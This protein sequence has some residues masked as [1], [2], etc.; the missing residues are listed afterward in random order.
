[1]SSSRPLAPPP[2]PP[3]PAPNTTRTG[4]LRLPG[5][6]RRQGL[7]PGPAEPRGHTAQFF[8][9]PRPIGGHTRPAKSATIKRPQLHLTKCQTCSRLRPG[10]LELEQGADQTG[11]TAPFSHL[12]CTSDSLYTILQARQAPRSARA[13]GPSLA[14]WQ[15]KRPIR[16]THTRTAGVGGTLL[17]RI[18]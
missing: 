16:A 9:G 7:G 6:A 18:G 8:L 2:R 13:T 12:P 5:P 14:P 15:P 17:F 3:R 4:G 1:M 10:A 11:L